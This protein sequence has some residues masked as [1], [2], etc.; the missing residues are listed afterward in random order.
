MEH[1]HGPPA[2]GQELDPPDSRSRPRADALKLSAAEAHAVRVALRRIAAA[3]GGFVALSVAMG[4]PTNTLYHAAN[5]K[6]R[7]R[8]TGTFA[9]RLAAV[10]GVPVEVLL[11]GKVVVSPV[12]IGVAA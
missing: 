1:V 6:N 12:V 2:A 5:P 8:P 10:A 11:G 3:R 4:V 9:I 7:G